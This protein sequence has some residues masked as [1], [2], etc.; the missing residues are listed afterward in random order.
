MLT[1][2]VFQNTFLGLDI[3]ISSKLGKT[4]DHFFTEK[5]SVLLYVAVFNISYSVAQPNLDCHNY[6]SPD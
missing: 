4:K 1:D 3:A 6:E 5:F 2:G